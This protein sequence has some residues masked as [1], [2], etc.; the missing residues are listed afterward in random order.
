MSAAERIGVGKRLGDV[1]HGEIWN[2][3]SIVVENWFFVMAPFDQACEY[4]FTGYEY[5]CNSRTAPV[6]RQA[7]KWTGRCNRLVASV[8]EYLDAPP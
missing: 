1:I 2:V 6:Q 3:E 7:A 8:P 4:R 5:D